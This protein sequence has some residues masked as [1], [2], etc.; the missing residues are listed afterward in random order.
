MPPFLNYEEPAPVTTADITVQL[1]SVSPESALRARP[2]PTPGI[3]R[4]QSLIGSRGLLKDLLWNLSSFGS[5]AYLST[6]AL[7]F[8]SRID[9]RAGIIKN[10]KMSTTYH[11]PADKKRTLLKTK[12]WDLWSHRGAGLSQVSSDRHQCLS[13]CFSAY[14]F[15]LFSSRIHLVMSQTVLLVSITRISDLKR[16]CLSCQSPL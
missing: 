8:L 3:S 11:D 4:A 2:L 9:C 16:T 5:P 7:S 13:V 15:I 14:Q 1:S 12:S 6:L 10:D